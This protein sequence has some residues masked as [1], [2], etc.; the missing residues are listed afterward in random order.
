MKK[1]ILLLIIV[2]LC[3]SAN[4]Q[5]RNRKNS[6][7]N[8]EIDYT[9][10][11]EYEISGIRVEGIKILDENALITLSGLK[12]G[13]RIKIPVDDISGGGRK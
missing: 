10:Q 7:N 12:I 6:S 9:Q 1:I 5:F 8:Y 13:D 3:D 11:G 4:A 2:A